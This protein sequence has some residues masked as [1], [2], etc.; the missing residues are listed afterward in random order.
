MCG[1]VSTCMCVHV[2]VCV[3]EILLNESRW[4]EVFVI[5]GNQIKKSGIF[6]LISVI[7]L[8]LVHMVCNLPSV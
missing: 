1:D 7:C 3:T 2:M 6:I 4:G 8:K 5:I